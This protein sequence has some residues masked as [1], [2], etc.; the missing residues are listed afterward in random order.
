MVHRLLHGLPL[1]GCILLLLISLSP[2]FALPVEAAQSPTPYIQQMIQYYRYYGEDAWGEIQDLL[3]YIAY[4]DPEKGALWETI[5]RSWSWCNS[6][7]EIPMDVLPDGLPEDDSL[8]IVVLG[9]AL[10]SDGSMQAELIDRLEVALESALKYPNAYVAVTG[11][12]TASKAATTE[13]EAMA[14]WL[15]QN[16]ICPDRLILETK[17]LSTTYNAVNT[18]TMFVRSY[19]TIKSLAVI[20]SDYHVPWGCAMFQAVCDYTQVYG[21][22]VIPVVGCAANYTGNHTD[23]MYYQAQGICAI[24]GIPFPTGGKPDLLKESG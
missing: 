10:K 23:T 15:I 6:E 13:A 24:T 17:S 7:M 1:W 9:Y 22:T 8:C 20:S 14:S 19:P 4:L 5:M 21:K 12:D 3:D 11:G 2:A 16:G 18:Y